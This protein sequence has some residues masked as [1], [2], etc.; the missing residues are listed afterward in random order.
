M[1]FRTNLRIRFILILIFFMRFS[2]RY[3]VQEMKV[4]ASKLKGKHNFL[5]DGLALKI[6]SAF[7]KIK[8]LQEKVVFSKEAMKAAIAKLNLIERAH[9]I[10]IPSAE[11]MIHTQFFESLSIAQDYKTLYDHLM[12]EV[13]LGLSNNAQTGI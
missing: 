4:R 10:R 7:L 13:K 12:A 1:T 3:K 5:K 8:S 6:K 9:S 11:D 2:I